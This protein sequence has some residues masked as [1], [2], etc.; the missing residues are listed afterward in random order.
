MCKSVKISD[1]RVK[2]PVENYAKKVKDLK[3]AKDTK[4]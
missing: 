1:M 2:Q 4:I 3:K